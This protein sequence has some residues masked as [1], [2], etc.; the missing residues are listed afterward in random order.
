MMERG[1]EKRTA[2]RLITIGVGLLMI[3]GLV[4]MA[5]VFMRGFVAGAA[6]ALVAVV[7]VMIWM[8]RSVRWDGE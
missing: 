3:V 7:C 1:T 4:L 5:R 6:F 8:S 2:G